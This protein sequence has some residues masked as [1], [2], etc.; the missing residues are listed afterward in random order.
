M[1]LRSATGFKFFNYSLLKQEFGAL[2]FEKFKRSFLG[3]DRTL[4][5][6]F[7]IS[8]MDNLPR[9]IQNTYFRLKESQALEISYAVVSILI[10]IISWSRFD[11]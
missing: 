5:H 1:R 6:F 11:F 8:T 10:C 2:V 7:A 4:F 9:S 3:Y